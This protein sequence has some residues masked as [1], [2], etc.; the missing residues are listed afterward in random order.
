MKFQSGTYR[1]QRTKAINIENNSSIFIL[2]PIFG[3]KGDMFYLLTQA[4]IC[5]FI[6]Y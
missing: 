1:L 5:T 2:L 4:D 6:L 3:V